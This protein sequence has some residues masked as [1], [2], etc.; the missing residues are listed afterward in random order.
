MLLHFHHSPVDTDFAFLPDGIERYGENDLLASL[1]FSVKRGDA[2]FELD[3]GLI[4]DELPVGERSRQFEQYG[5]AIN[6]AGADSGVQVES[7]DCFGRDR[8]GGIVESD[9]ILSFECVSSGCQEQFSFTGDAEDGLIAV[10][11]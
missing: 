4:C 8:G 2:F 10:V 11:F 3:E 7:D 6:D 5:F 1:R 9:G